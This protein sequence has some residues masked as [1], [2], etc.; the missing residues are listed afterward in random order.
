MVMVH[1]RTRCQFYKAPPTG[2]PSARSKDAVTVPVIAN[3]DGK[4]A[5]RP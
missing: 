3:G 1:G 4:T 5:E 2:P